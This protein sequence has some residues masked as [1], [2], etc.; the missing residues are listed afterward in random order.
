MTRIITWGAH[1]ARLAESLRAAGRAVIEVDSR[2]AAESAALTDEVGVLVADAGLAADVAAVRATRVEQGL[3]GLRWIALGDETAAQEAVAA[4]ADWAVPPWPALVAG[5][6][7]SALDAVRRERDLM[8]THRDTFFALS[9]D[10]FCIADFQGYFKQLNPAWSALGWSFEEL[11]AKPFL[12]FVH[13][14]DVQPTLDIMG[15]LTT[16][17]FA[18]ISFENRYRC[19][20]GTYRWLLWSS[21][22]SHGAARPEDRF[23]FAVARDI[24]ERKAREA[25]LRL[26]TERLARSNAELEQFAHIASHDLQEPLRMVGSYVRLLE[27]RYRGQL[28]EQA[29]KYIHFAADGA[30]R[31]QAL[32]TDLLAF[33]RVGADASTPAVVDADEICR[34]VLDDLGATLMESAARVT[35]E[36]LPPVRVDPVQLR[37]VFL[38]LIGNAV[39]FHRAEAPPRVHV[40]ALVEAGHAHFT[41]ADNGIGIDPQNFQRI[42]ELFQRLHTRTEYPGTGLGLAIVKKIVERHRGRIWVDSTPGEGTTFHFTLPA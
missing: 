21:R 32:I 35:A 5:V 39:K 9:L 12:D 7:T 14:D 1:A 41:V 33:A 22:T 4:G 38:N 15:K 29:D 30:Q 42:F 37:Q 11:Q 23:Y 10:M 40:S 17:D 27:K 8:G 36:H 20:D 19:K 26:Q 2:V 6:V 28:D 25:E 24:T 16:S 34:R 31:M 13:P 18:T 3:P